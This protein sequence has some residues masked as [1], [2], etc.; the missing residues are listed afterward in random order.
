MHII[1]LFIKEET[2]LHIN[3]IENL[4]YF[5]TK[6]ILAEYWISQDMEHYQ[7]FSRFNNILIYKLSILGRLLC[8][9]T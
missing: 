3:W 1:P 2:D 9:N 6:L 7:C 8:I 4:A 5:Y